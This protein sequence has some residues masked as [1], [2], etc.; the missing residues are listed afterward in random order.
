MVQ[1]AVNLTPED[2]PD[3]ARQLSALGSLLDTRYQR[4]G[5]LE[6]LEAAITLY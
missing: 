2:H 5:D 3:Q 6:D 1:E 4:T